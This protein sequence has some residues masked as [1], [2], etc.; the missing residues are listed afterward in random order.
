[1]RRLCRRV[2]FELETIRA[3]VEQGQ[4]INRMILDTLV[5]RPKAK[6]DRR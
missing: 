5:V 1:M 2:D 3:C 6:A 4:G